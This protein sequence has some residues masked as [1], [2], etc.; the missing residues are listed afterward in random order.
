MRP[1]DTAYIIERLAVRFMAMVADH[2]RQLAE[3]RAS[4]GARTEADEKIIAGLREE[5]DRLLANL[6]QAEAESR[7]ARDALR[8]EVA[9]LQ[10]RL[11]ASIARGDFAQM[12]VAALKSQTTKHPVKVGEWVRRT[13]TGSVAPIGKVGLVLVVWS[14]AYEVQLRKGFSTLWSFDDCTPCGPPTE[15][16]HDTPEGKAAAVKT[17]PDE[18]K[19]GDVIRATSWKAGQAAHVKKILSD[20]RL[21]LDCSDQ[22]WRVDEVVKL[23]RKVTT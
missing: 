5:R 4:F 11:R 6:T 1:Q 17:E 23:A 3:H 10:E 21:M 7:V 20:G 15:A 14:D 19:V 2:E 16:T 22:P 12:E 9:A 8:V 18:I 13:T